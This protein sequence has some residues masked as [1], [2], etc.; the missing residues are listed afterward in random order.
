MSKKSKNRRPPSR[1]HQK[2]PFPI[3]VVL[4]VTAIIATLSAVTYYS[5]KDAGFVKADANGCF[6]L[7]SGHTFALVDS[8]DPRFDAAQ[9][10][11]LRTAFDQLY[12]SEMAFNERFTI[13]TTEESRIGSIPAPAMVF[14]RSAHTGSELAAVGA[15]SAT[16]AYL[17]R[18]AVSFFDQEFSPV[19][20][21]IFDPN[22][23]DAQRQRRE[24]PIME[25][26]QGVARQASFANSQG[27]RRLI[28]VSDMIQSTQEAQFCTKQGHLPSFETF[29]NSAYFDRVRPA[30]LAGVEVE[31]YMLIR[32]GYG[33]T[34]LPYCSEDELRS[35][36]TDYFVDAGASSVEIIRLRRG[37]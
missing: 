24:S 19:M 2:S 14:C 30:S 5:V 20:A 9:T 18:E 31:L 35:F 1:R 8:S 10:R 22:P 25:Q 29:K 4:G 12:A 36:W 26:V 27:Q 32:G 23:D 34:F 28:I 13:V 11:D 7:D 33:G 17:A 6:P 3:K 21:D 16:P 15:A 37:G